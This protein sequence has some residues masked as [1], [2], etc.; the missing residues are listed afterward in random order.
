MSQESSQLQKIKS[1][2]STSSNI[3]AFQTINLF[4]SNETEDLLSDPNIYRA[5]DKYKHFQE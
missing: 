5:Y 4:V 2:C 1:C 3:Y